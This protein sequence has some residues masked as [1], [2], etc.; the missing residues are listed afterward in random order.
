MGMIG[1]HKTN[2]D[3]YRGMTSKRMDSIGKG[4]WLSYT[5][6]EEAL[7]AKYPE[8]KILFATSNQTSARIQLTADTE[9]K[10]YTGDFG[11]IAKTLKLD[12]VQ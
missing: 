4:K 8:A 9:P 12:T 2:H 7:T 3:R 5:A 10:N 11:H 1:T 6:L